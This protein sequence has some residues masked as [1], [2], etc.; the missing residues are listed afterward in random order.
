MCTSCKQHN[1]LLAKRPANVAKKLGL[2]SKVNLL[3]SKDILSV[4]KDRKVILMA[5]N[6]RI[7]HVVPGIMRAAAELDAIVGY[8]MALSEGDVDGGY[9]GQDP[10]T[11]FETIVGYAEALN[12]TKPFFIHGD[13]ITI[14][15]TAEKDVE[16]G[17]K[18][19]AAEL[20]NGYTSFA[21]DAS[22]NQIPDNIKITTDLAQPILKAGL[23]LEVEV[24]EVGPTGKEAT[25]TTLE[26]GVS[27]IEGLIKNNVH[28]DMLAI[29]NGSKH[30]NYLEGEKIF[31]DLERTGE[32][33][34]AI[35][36]HGVVIAQHGITGTPLHLIGRFADY[37]IRKGNVGTQ[38]QNIAHEG[39]P[40]ELMEEMNK[41]CKETG[42]NIKM[43]T[44]PFKEKIDN[45]P[46]S[47]KDFIANKAYEEAKILIK[48]FSA[49]GT[50]TM[51]AEG[52]K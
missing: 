35:K 30:G 42:K 46:Q 32:I 19:I 12:F 28:P 18:L 37:G 31:I 15:S 47:N 16:R 27:F 21:I 51:V 41:W 29:N 3:N 4:L 39:L 7:K 40:K 36:Q 52:L 6:T 5:C 20:E 45:I 14:K 33:Y 23:G 9:T 24:G 49:E 50:A 13:H 11:Y 25:L 44:K 48:G 2:S 22:F 34:N 10:K 1:A 17:R 43:A 8:E 26:E 38:W